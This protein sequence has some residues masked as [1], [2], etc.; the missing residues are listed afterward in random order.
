MGD[1]STAAGEAVGVGKFVIGIWR[2]AA[3]TGEAP[4][5][6]MGNTKGRGLEGL[7]SLGLGRCPAATHRLLP[8]PPGYQACRVGQGCSLRNSR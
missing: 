2:A 4:A 3:G 5:R 1:G 7:H 8:A 6:D